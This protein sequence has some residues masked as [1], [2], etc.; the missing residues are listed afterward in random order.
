VHP[1][2]NNPSIVTLETNGGEAKEPRIRHGVRI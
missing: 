1:L 2:N